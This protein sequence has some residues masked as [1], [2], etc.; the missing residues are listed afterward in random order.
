MPELPEV[1]TVRRTLE[2][3]VAGK[4]I[5]TAEIS[6]PRIIKRPD[7]AL[8]FA[9]MLEGQR[10][11]SIGRQGKFLKINLQDYVMVSHLRMEGKYE[12]GSGEEPDKHTHV[13]FFFADGSELRYRDVRKFGTMHLFEKGTEQSEMPLRQ[14]GPEPINDEAF[15]AEYLSACFTKTA[16]DVKTVLLDQRVV[17]GLGNIYVDEALF[18][19]GIRPGAKAAAL[20]HRQTE[21]LW[22]EINCT[23]DEAVKKGGSTVRSYVNG[24]GEMGMFQLELNVY[25][26]KDEPC[27]TCGIPIEKTVVA[28]RGTH[29]CPGCQPA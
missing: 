29:Y 26:R 9:A 23:I 8:A 15:T 3:L 16:R 18:R 17:A 27:H 25:G 6:W 10:I 7:D 12:M 2:K 14:L 24:A 11:E 20:N 19:A 21:K 28:G 4:T 13:R 22:N 1:E 5:Q